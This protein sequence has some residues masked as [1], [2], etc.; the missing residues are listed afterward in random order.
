MNNLTVRSIDIMKWTKDTRKSQ[1]PD[2]QKAEIIKVL[3]AN[4]NLTHIAIA[5]FLNKE[6]DYLTPSIPDDQWVH[7]KKW[8][9]LIHAR[10]LNVIFRGIHLS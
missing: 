5:P 9:D 10:G 1:I 3:A 7:T 8:V 6:S 2:S 4:F